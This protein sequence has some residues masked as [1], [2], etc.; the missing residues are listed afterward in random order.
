MTNK[1]ESHIIIAV[2]LVLS[3]AILAASTT[4]LLTSDFYAKETINWQTQ[5]LVQDMVDLSIIVPVLLVSGFLSRRFITGARLIWTATLLYIVYTFTIY[6]FDVHFNKLFLLYC[7]ILGVSIYSF[8][9]VSLSVRSQPIKVQVASNGLS[10]VTGIYLLTL[11]LSFIFFWL[12]EIIPAIRQGAAPENLASVELATN[13][14]H[15]LDLSL[16]LPGMLFSSILILKR[17]RFGPSLAILFLTFLVLMDITIAWLS[18]VLNQEELDSNFTVGVVMSV[19]ALFSIVLL[20]IHL[21]KT[22]AH[23]GVNHMSA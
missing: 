17:N 11:S 4:A 5:S 19:L 9:W 1:K 3:L 6:C 16:L 12:S 22:P 7:F 10:L 20:I 18:F 13:P 21:R 15:V 8:V 14:V 23:P 2:S